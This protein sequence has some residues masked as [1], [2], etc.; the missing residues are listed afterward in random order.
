MEL[1]HVSSSD[2]NLNINPVFIPKDTYV[3]NKS[4][5]FIPKFVQIYVIS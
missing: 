3:A 5:S 4:P 1:S 2:F